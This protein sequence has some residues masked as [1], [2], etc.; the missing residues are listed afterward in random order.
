MYRYVT[1]C[2]ALVGFGWKSKTN[3]TQSY[4]Q[5]KKIQINQAKQVG[6]TISHPLSFFIFYLQLG[7]RKFICKK[8]KIRL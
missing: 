7:N 2:S 4:G 1:S 3:I 6:S 5:P 8:I